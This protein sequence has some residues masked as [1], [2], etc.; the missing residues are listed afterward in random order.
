MIKF[1]KDNTRFF[2]V[3]LILTVLI[4]WM[5]INS[6]NKHKDYCIKE[7]CEISKKLELYEYKFG[8]IW[9]DESGNIHATR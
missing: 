8:K 1:F 6:E 7:Y 5:Y 2:V 3:I 9:L 4:Q